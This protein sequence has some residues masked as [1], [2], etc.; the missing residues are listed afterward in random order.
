VANAFLQYLCEEFTSRCGGRAIVAGGSVR[1]ILMEREPKDFDV[2]VIGGHFNADWSKG[3]E[4][5]E[6]PDW[7]KSEPHLQ[8]TFRIDG[9]IVQVMKAESKS[10]AEVLDLFDWNVSR[11]AYDA[12]AKVDPFIRLTKLDDI[13]EGK[14]LVLH[15]VTYPV[16]S[17]RRGFRFSERFAMKFESADMMRLCVLSSA[18]LVEVK[19]R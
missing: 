14:S 8:A 17:L 7:H 1:D 4:R 18:R 10:P 11:F 5:I 15:R 16:S 6:S 2:F 19:P 3:C 12:T 9:K 13:A